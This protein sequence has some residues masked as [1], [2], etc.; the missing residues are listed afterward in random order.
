VILDTAKLVNQLKVNEEEAML[1]T[2]ETTVESAIAK[3]YSPHLD[4]VVVTMGAKGCYYK[5]RDGEG[6]VPCIDVKVVDTTGAGDAFNAGLISG[7]YAKQKRASEL[8]KTELEDILH[9]AVVIGSLTTTK[10]G[11]VTAFP[12]KKEIASH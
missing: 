1:L 2:G 7:L 8:T 6:A 3:L 11:A 12:S 4:L 5:T 10:K 9:R